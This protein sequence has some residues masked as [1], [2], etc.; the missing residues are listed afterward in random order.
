VWIT[1]ALDAV[2]ANGPAVDVALGGKEPMVDLWEAGRLVPT[3][4]QLEAL[5][6]YTGRDL[7]YFYQP[8][9]RIIGRACP[10]FRPVYEDDELGKAI[11]RRVEAEA[12]PGGR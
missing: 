5:C 2:G 9:P 7:S 1:R 3:P 12:E 10:G 11:R 8:T 6:C 4:E